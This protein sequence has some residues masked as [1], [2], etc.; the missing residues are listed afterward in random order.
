MNCVECNKLISV[1]VDNEL[2]PE[3]AGWVRLHLASCSD[4]A[5]VFEDF[6]A[7]LDFCNNDNTSDVVPPNSRALWC[8]INNM[9]ETELKPQVPPVEE[10]PQGFWQFSFGQLASA[11]LCIAVVSSLLTVVAVRN[12]NQPAESDL[13][14]RSLMTQTLFEKFLSRIGAI[15][16]P[17]DG[18][19]RRLMQHQAAIEY[20]N[21]RV[22][23]RRVQWDRVTREAFDR[24]L[25]VI[26]E[27]VHEYQMI[28]QENPEDALSGEM[29]DS[30]LEDKTAL[31]RDFSDL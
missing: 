25:N 5:R 2:D 17:Q 19:D 16:T 28:L 13:A 14:D 27:A 20:W 26:D 18:R 4:C 10:P 11:V 21:G 6:S 24:N 3:Q 31:L 1:F 30:V 15:E 7:I 12:Y 8:R 23:E 9:I 29:L 22:Q